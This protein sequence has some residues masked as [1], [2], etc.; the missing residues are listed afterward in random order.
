MT[1]A[2]VVVTSLLD[3]AS[4]RD[5]LAGADLAGTVV[6]NVTTG[7]PEEAADLADW[8]GDRGA[9]YLDGV[10]MAV[11]QSIGTPDALLLYSGPDA[12]FEK[13]RDVL[14]PLGTTHHLGTDPRLAGTY[15]LALLSAGYAALGGFL[16]ASALLGAAGVGPGELL[17]VLRHWLSGIIAFMP[18]LGGE[19]EHRHCADGVSS[20]DLNRTAVDLVVETSGARGVDPALML[21]L[22][23]LLARRAA[24]GHGTDSFASL[25]E[26]LRISPK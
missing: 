2:E 26:E 23:D 6:V 4:V 12:A 14:A 8:T 22:R 19:I 7:R 15:D 18:E 16:H 25:V 9:A 11:P 10:M 21:P 3:P 24:A 20:V 1:G 5:V 17:P 13:A